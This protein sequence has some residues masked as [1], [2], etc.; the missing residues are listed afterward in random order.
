MSGIQ[1]GVHKIKKNK[2]KTSS[3]ISI[4]G[5][6]R[7]KLIIEKTFNHIILLGWNTFVLL[8]VFLM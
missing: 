6:N 7:I 2:Y 8:L 5:Q 4:T 3:I 1:P